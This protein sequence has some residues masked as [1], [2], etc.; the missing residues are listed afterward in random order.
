M[1]SACCHRSHE[2]TDSPLAH[3]Y[4]SQMMVSSVF[5]RP[6][7]DQPLLAHP[8]EWMRVRE[9]RRSC[10]SNDHGRHDQSADDKQHV[11]DARRLT[12]LHLTIPS[13]RCYG[14]SRSH[15]H[16]G[17]SAPGPVGGC[18]LHTVSRFAA[19]RRSP[20]LTML[21]LSNTLRVLWPDSFIATCEVDW[22][23][24]RR[25]Q[26]ADGATGCRCDSESG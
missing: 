16:A 21:Y 9:G 19:S 5:G 20:S 17:K 8:A 11:V 1:D 26:H 23:H 18:A 4:Q 6:M 24:W 3:W 25:P 13:Q 7:L 2:P 12:R 10:Y 14:C 15:N 22:A